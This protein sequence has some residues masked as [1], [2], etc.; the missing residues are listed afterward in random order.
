MAYKVIDDARQIPRAESGMVG[1]DIETFP[2]LSVK[3]TREQRERHGIDPRLS[4]I[5]VAQVEADGQVY[6]LLD[7]FGSLRGLLEDRGTKK[8]IQTGVFEYKNFLHHEGIRINGMIDPGI[9]E[10][11]VECGR[12]RSDRHSL[13]ALTQKYLGKKLDKAVRKSF[14]GGGTKITRKMLEYAATDAEVLVPIYEQQRQQAY[15]GIDRVA[16]LEFSLI[17][18]VAEIELHGI[19]IDEA[20]WMSIY[21]ENVD[22]LADTEMKLMGYSATK[23]RRTTMFG[24]EETGENLNS[25]LVKQRMFKNRGIDV[26]NFRHSTLE[27][28]FAKTEDEMVGLFLGYAGLQKATTTYGEEFLANINP[29]TKRIH[30]SIRQ[31]ET[32]TGRLAGR[33]PNMMNIPKASNYRGCFTAGPGRVFAVA[34]YSA[35]EYRILAELCHDPNLLEAFEQGI[36]VHIHG[37]RILF[38]DSS[39]TD[40]D[41]PRRKQAKNLN[42]GLVYGMGEEK[43]AIS[44]GVSRQVARRLKEKH[45][46]SYPNAAMYMAEAIADAAKNGYVK[47]LLGRLRYVDTSDNK[48]ERIARNTPIQGSA[49][50]MTKLAVLLLSQEL[51][52]DSWVVNV[53]HDEI[54]VECPANKGKAMLELLRAT[55]VDAAGFLVKTV[56]F[57]TDGYVSPRWSPERKRMQ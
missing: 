13:D 39:I 41:D 12:A 5:A 3:V 45:Q 48:Y 10:G 38:D 31:V 2:D 25:R 36:D 27:E 29:V 15:E 4:K 37:A 17:P 56:P 8:V 23:V 34:D 20:A 50:D 54:V 28:Y 46:Q 11:L 19:A 52:Q 49:A 53:V 24:T 18:A 14:I 42:F 40:K 47:T 57:D 44:L 6:I 55:M 43:L 35:Q 32:R 1:L 21:D 16:K 9:Y 7:N 26:P 51:P 22:K 30:Q 33:N